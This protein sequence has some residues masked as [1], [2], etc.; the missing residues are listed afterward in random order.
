MT[1]PSSTNDVIVPIAMLAMIFEM[2]INPFGVGI[3]YMNAK[4]N[5]HLFCKVKTLPIF[6]PNYQQTILLK[7]Q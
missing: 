1:T 6:V 2:V 3:E 5:K 4:N 7:N